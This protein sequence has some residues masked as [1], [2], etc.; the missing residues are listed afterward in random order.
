MTS[1]LTRY[2]YES[3]SSDRVVDNPDPDEKDI[4]VKI[5]KIISE[6]ISIRKVYHF[7][8]LIRLFVSDMSKITSEINRLKKNEIDG[9]QFIFTDEETEN[10]TS[11]PINQGKEYLKNKLSRKLKKFL[12]TLTEFESPRMSSVIQELGQIFSNVKEEYLVRDFSKQ[13]IYSD[14]EEQLYFSSDNLNNYITYLEHL[15]NTSKKNENFLLGGPSSSFAVSKLF[16]NRIIFYRV[17]FSIA[18]LGGITWLYWYI[19][20]IKPKQEQK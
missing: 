9:T 12:N 3:I 1:Q 14:A 11:V 19:F 6:D 13:I 4:F 17:L 15:K 20:M 10:I 2:N 8:E 18:G 7:Q 5:A 16:D